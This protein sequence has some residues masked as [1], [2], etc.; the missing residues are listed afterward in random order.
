MIHI[1]LK[2]SL[3]SQAH[4]AS[5]IILLFVSTIRQFEPMDYDWC[6]WM[7]AVHLYISAMREN[8]MLWPVHQTAWN[9]I[10]P[11]I[12]TFRSPT[13]EQNPVS[14][15][16]NHCKPWRKGTRKSKDKWRL[17]HT[18][19]WERQSYQIIVSFTCAALFFRSFECAL[20]AVPLMMLVI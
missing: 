6:D 17:V 1:D 12:L 5:E 2:Q 14:S 15:P 9:C 18:D 20:S 7:I 16:C 3:T 11:W 8:D 4:I 10:D 13:H 19:A